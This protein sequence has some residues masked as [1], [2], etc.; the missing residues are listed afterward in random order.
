MQQLLDYLRVCACVRVSVRMCK[1]DCQRDYPSSVSF[2]KGH[3]FLHEASSA[4][5]Q[6]TH[7]LEDETT[8]CEEVHIWI[9][10]Y[11][12]CVH[13]LLVHMRT[14]AH[15]QLPPGFVHHRFWSMP[16]YQLY[17]V[18][19]PMTHI[20][21]GLNHAHTVSTHTQ[22]HTHVDLLHVSPAGC[23]FFFLFFFLPNG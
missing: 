21:H 8:H 11:C 19:E 18:S 14:H 2:T 4:A 17:I 23:F 10:R 5:K 22:T 16:K 1:L 12:M 6:R 9:R 20:K 15:T 13:V 3:M 7:S